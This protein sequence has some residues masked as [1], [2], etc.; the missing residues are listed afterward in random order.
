MNICCKCTFTAHAQ[1]AV[2]CNFT[3]WYSLRWGNLLKNTSEILVKFS[4]HKKSKKKKKSEESC[5]N[6]EK[7]IRTNKNPLKKEKVINIARA[8]QSVKM[9]IFW[10]ILWEVKNIW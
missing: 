9:C 2:L 5:I 10:N 7:E 8:S 3:M 6:R 4:Q 1:T